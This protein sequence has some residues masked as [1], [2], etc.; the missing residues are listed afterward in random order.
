[1]LEN[2]YLTDCWGGPLYVAPQLSSI[3][4]KN[5]HFTIIPIVYRAV[6]QEIIMNMGQH[7]MAF[8]NRFRKLP[9]VHA[10]LGHHNI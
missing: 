10:I 3:Y 2:N 4:D 9:L 6:V 1:M 7:K 8:L 5:T